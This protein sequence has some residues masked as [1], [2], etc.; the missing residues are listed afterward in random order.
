MFSYPVNL[1]IENRLCL[2]VGGGVVAAR[3]INTLLLCKARVRVISPHVCEVIGVLAEK[4]KIEWL[5]RGYEEGDV[6]GALL[7]IATTDKRD[8]QNL[9]VTEASERQILVNVV[10]DPSACTFQVP[11]MVR[12]GE[13]L[14][15]VSTGG[16]SPALS[17]R[18]KKKIEEEY[19]PEY[20]LFVDLL[21]KIR[22]NI[23]ND[24]GT[25]TS[26][27]IFFEKLLQLNILTYIRQ[28]NWSAL[29]KELA[30][31]LPEGIDPEQ[32]IYAA[33]LVKQT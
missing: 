7:V 3:K 18:I 13:F 15:T 21:A 27:K 19:G 30:E 22:E 12:R 10:D 14:L 32:L 16:G 2:I 25:Q 6:Q 4:G 8:I 31:L 1:S 24:G 17:A 29:Q 5:Q 23:V 26:H 9:I 28:E 11:A 20:G 33:G